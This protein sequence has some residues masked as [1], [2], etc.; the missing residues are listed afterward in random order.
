LPVSVAGIGYDLFTA[1]TPDPDQVI[2]L[3]IDLSPLIPSTASATPEASPSPFFRVGDT[4]S[5]KTGVIFDHNGHP[6]PDG[7]GV[8][9]NI[10]LSGEGG[11]VQ[12]IDAVTLQGIAGVSFS[13]DRPGLLEIR[14]ESDPAFTSVVLQLDVSNEGFGVTVV[15][16]TPITTPTPTLEPMIT[17]EI[18]PSPPVTQGYP[19]VGEWFG[20]VLTLG[21]LGSLAYWLGKRTNATR[22]AVRYALCMI[23]GGLLAYSYLAI[24]L[25]GAT[26]YLQK[27]GWLGL[28]GVVILGAIVGFGAA[29][30][31]QRLSSGSTKQ[32]D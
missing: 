17:P 7:T 15:A 27:N 21:G 1:T 30:T 8:R 25:P 26:I 29:Y 18:T 2:Q 12:Q 16:P 9:F 14:A 4:V 20:M 24:R 32:P 13:I 5:V 28:M 19:N 22:W 6:V 23:A 3:S 31:W 11:V 10:N